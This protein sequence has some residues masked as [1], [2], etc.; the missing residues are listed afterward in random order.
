VPTLDPEDRLR[1]K[2]IL[3]G[4]LPTASRAAYLA[5]ACHD[6]PALGAEN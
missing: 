3:E 1:L 2:G 5:T 6:N 4:A